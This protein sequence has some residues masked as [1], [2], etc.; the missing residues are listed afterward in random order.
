MQSKRAKKGKNMTKKSILAAAIT[1]MVAASAMSFST[2]ALA[3]H[4]EGK[5]ECHGVNACKGKGECGGKGHGCHGKNS[6]KGKGW[7]SMTEKECQAKKGK[8][9]KSS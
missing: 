7:V 6:C 8:F 4:H 9:K 5:G 2:S 3:D 1:G